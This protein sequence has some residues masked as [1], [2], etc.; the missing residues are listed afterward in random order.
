MEKGLESVLNKQEQQNVQTI[1]REEEV[2][3]YDDQFADVNGMLINN[4]D[5]NKD[6]IW[7]S[8]NNL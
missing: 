6:A 5:H 4:I 1:T 7:G 8:M 3:D 2:Y